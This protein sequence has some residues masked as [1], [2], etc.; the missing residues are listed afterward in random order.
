MRTTL[1]SDAAIAALASTLVLCAACN[2]SSPAGSPDRD[3]GIPG[4]SDSGDGVADG[5]AGPVDAGVGEA[6]DDETGDDGGAP[7]PPQASL[8][9]AQWSPDA[10]AFDVCVAPHGT[11]SFE[12]PFIQA[13]FN[14]AGASSN[15][16]GSGL[17][18][19]QV[20]AY[21]AVPSGPYDVR[22]VAADA[23]SCDV[24]LALDG[25]VSIADTT[26]LPAL[27]TASFNTLLATGVVYP[28][29]SDQRFG[30][31][32]IVDDA[33]LPNGAAVV[34]AINALPSGPTQ[35]FGLGAF[36]GAWLPLLTDVKFGAAS[37]E[38]APNE[39]MVD[40]NGYLP[41]SPL[42]DA[43]MSARASAG[44]SSDTA[45]SHTVTIQENS[46]STIIAIGGDAAGAHPLQLLLCV[47]NEP[48][49]AALSDCSI[50]Q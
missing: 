36:A 25:G 12:G 17:S 24:P 27:T 18:Y 32:A 8:R 50:T 14:A 19:P 39:G 43:T 5:S 11:E 44:A 47:D 45:V 10:P 22:V 33:V 15:D 6:G 2:G 42:D 29:G 48:S 30:L 20:S 46:V 40:S 37:A 28:W 9:V 1:R 13:L 49:G 16:A 7:G 23:T 3:G 35:D 38:A 26:D 41:I 21:F 4:I 34:R 31:T